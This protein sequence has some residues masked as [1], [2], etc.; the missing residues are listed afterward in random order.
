M[1]ECES[2][3]PRAMNNCVLRFNRYMVECEYRNSDCGNQVFIV[4]IDTW[5]NV[6]FYNESGAEWKNNVLIDTWWNV[7]VLYKKFGIYDNGF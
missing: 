4:L 6:N 3:T 5:W 7:N 1:V 2:F